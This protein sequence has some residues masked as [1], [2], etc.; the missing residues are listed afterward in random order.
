M[1]TTTPVVPPGMVPPAVYSVERLIL[2]DDFAVRTANPRQ[3]TAN[4]PSSTTAGPGS[5]VPGF[6]YPRWESSTVPPRPAIYSNRFGLDPDPPL[7]RLPAHNSQ[8]VF[9]LFPF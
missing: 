3:A 8:T 7:T 6:S 2:S 9:T 1:T 4:P 5:T